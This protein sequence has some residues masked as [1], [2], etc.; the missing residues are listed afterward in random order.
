MK[1]QIK[2]PKMG[3]LLALLLFAVFAACILLVLLM[4]AKAYKQLVLRDNESYDRRTATQYIITR[5]RQSDLDG[6]FSVRK[7]SVGDVLAMSE[8]VDGS[9]YE[10]LVYCYDGYLRELFTVGDSEFD[11]QAGEKIL[12]VELFAVQLE[13]GLLSVELELP[14]GDADNIVMSVRSGEGAAE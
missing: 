12:P 7:E 11:P 14:N 6:A 9:E 3:G 1:E 5:V 2:K 10:T 8:E 13:E 4:G